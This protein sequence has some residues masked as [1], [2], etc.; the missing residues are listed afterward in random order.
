MK[1]ILQIIFLF[2]ILSISIKAGKIANEIISCK[3]DKPQGDVCAVNLTSTYETTKAN[4]IKV[5]T[6]CQEGE[7]CIK[8]SEFSDYGNPDKMQCVKLIG[9]RMPG[10]KCRYH[11]DCITDICVDG[12]CRSLREG[13]KCNSDI[14]QCEPGTSCPK[15]NKFC[16]KLV[17]K[18]GEPCQDDFNSCNYGLKCNSSTKKCQKIGDVPVGGECG[19]E[20]LVCKTG[21]CYKGTCV[22]VKTDGICKNDGDKIMCKG[23]EL[24]GKKYLEDEECKSY[25]GDPGVAE[26]YFCTISK[27]KEKLFKKYLKKFKKVKLNR[28]KK[29]KE[30]LYNNGNYKYNFGIG[31]LSELDILY[32]NA[33]DFKARNYIDD[34]G[35]FIEENICEA[36]WMLKYIIGNNANKIKISYLTLGF[37]L[38]ASLL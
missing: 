8:A 2:Q 18:E 34:N 24:D 31:E 26:N 37:I 28:I 21:L 3:D 35:D 17:E 29:S 27:A 10:H 9:A 33:P 6:A 19:N 11:T 38:I 22:S 20:D 32:Y 15:G 30:S 7:I 14:P 16:T 4:S 25:V 5:K 12:I 36:K 23:L 13:S 1:H